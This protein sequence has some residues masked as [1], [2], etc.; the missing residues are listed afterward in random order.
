MLRDCLCKHRIAMLK[1]M[2]NPKAVA[3]H[4]CHAAALT[5]AAILTP[6]RIR[7]PRSLCTSR[8]LDRSNWAGCREIGSSV[9]ILGPYSRWSLLKAWPLAPCLG[10]PEICQVSCESSHVRMFTCALLFY[11]CDP[12]FTSCRAGERQECDAYR[13]GGKLCLPLSRVMLL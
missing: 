7:I 9:P 13:H 3:T 2:P 1:S 10:T 5:R 4:A 8:E 6:G 11:L 12:I